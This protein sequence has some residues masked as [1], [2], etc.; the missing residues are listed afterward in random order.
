MEHSIG[1]TARQ[2]GAGLGLK[3]SDHAGSRDQRFVFDTLLGAQLALI[4][5]AREIIN[6]LLRLFASSKARKSTRDLGAESPPNR[7]QHAIQ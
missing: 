3:N 2:H 4:C 7:L 1:R 6:A 5:A